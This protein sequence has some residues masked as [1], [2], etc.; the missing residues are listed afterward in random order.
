V[1]SLLL[2]AAALSGPPNA[3]DTT[4]DF[5][6]HPA[7]V[8]L[9]GKCEV[10]RV[11][12]RILSIVHAFNTGHGTVLATHFTRRPSFQPYVGD[13]GRRYAQRPRVTRREL[14]RFVNS[15]YAARD[16]WTVS[17]LMPPQG[18]AGLPSTA[19]Y[20]LGLTVSYPGGSLEGGAKI[21]VSC[22]SGFVTRWV[23][24]AYGRAH[25]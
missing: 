17:A 22:S 1:L 25:P 8:Q 24:P 19:I 5:M 9:P 11:Q 10:A 3:P 18:T 16:G 23:G 15:R 6:A 4:P 14:V 21:V 2:A 12:S 20:G 13:I 7:G